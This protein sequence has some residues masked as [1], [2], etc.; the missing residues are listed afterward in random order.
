MHI[1]IIMF[2]QTIAE[3]M[4]IRWKISGDIKIEIL[5]MI[6]EIEEIQEHPF[7][8][9]SQYLVNYL[10]VKDLFFKL[11]IIYFLEHCFKLNKNIC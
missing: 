10:K 3:I 7:G 5:K 1:N 6:L 8:L 2:G 11:F 4:I 9:C